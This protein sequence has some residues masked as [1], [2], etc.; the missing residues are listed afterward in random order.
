MNK[1]EME[2]KRDEL[3]ESGDYSEGES[4]SFYMSEIEAF[5]NGWD[6]CANEYELRIEKLRQALKDINKEELRSQR[7]GGEYS[8]SARISYE[9]LLADEK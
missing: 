7:P 2:K 6:A 9:A 1:E 4:C 5:K 3:A 8:K